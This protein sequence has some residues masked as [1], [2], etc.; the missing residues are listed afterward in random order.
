M[1]KTRDLSR[2]YSTLIQLVH[3]KLLDAKFSK[4]LSSGFLFGVLLNIW[5]ISIGGVCV[6]LFNVCRN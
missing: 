3:V 1:E 2:F 6:S 5:A 4:R